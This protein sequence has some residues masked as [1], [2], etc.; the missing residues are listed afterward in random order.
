[1]VEMRLYVEGGGDAKLLRT[2]CRRGFAEF[3]TKAGLHGHMPRI[4]ACGG[5]RQAYDD[6]CIALKQGTHA[7]MLLVDGEDPVTDGSSWAHLR[8]RPGDRWRAPPGSTDDDCHLMVQCMESWFL[9]DHDTLRSFFGQGFRA[10]GLPA[11]GS[12]VESVSKNS[13]Y[14]MLAGAT[15][16]C[17]TR[18][19]Y[20]KG[21]HSFDLLARIDPG[22][23]LAGSSWAAHFVTVLRNRMG[24]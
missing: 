22:K 8:R 10:G 20:G 7:A 6:F 4:V 11:P 5:R 19:P 2:A 24:C 12:E 16:N 9:T 23:V 14:E 17:K 3:L 15:A 21:E 1:M 18:A 13:V